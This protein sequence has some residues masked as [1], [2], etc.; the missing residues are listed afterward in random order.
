MEIREKHGAHIQIFRPS[1]VFATRRTDSRYERPRRA[2]PCT[3]FYPV[4]VSVYA[5]SPIIYILLRGR[6]RP[7]AA[8]SRRPFSQPTFFSPRIYHF[9]KTFRSPSF[10]SPPL[11][12][13]P[14]QSSLVRSPPFD[15]CALISRIYSHAWREM[16][17]DRSILVSSQR[18]LENISHLGDG[19][20]STN[21]VLKYN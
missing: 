18:D 4:R 12:D 10:L 2:D 19:V 6:S 15:L 16:R 13:M 3:G 1:P 17:F 7:P 11:I 8:I 5:Y 9:A 20:R 14:R 21:E